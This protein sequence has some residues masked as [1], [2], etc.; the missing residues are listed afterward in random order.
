VSR[1][2][3]RWVAL[4]TGLV[5]GLALGLVY[6][7]LVTPVELVNTYPALLRADYRQEWV[8]LVALSYAADGDLARARSRL[9]G[10]DQQ[11]V[12]GAVAA[13]IEECASAGYPADTLRRL[14]ALAVALDVHTPAMLVYLHTPTRQPSL[15]P[16]TPTPSPSPTYTSSPTHAP[17]PSPTSTPTRTPIPTV[18]S[19][20]STPT[21]RPTDTPL[22]PTPTPAPGPAFLV[23]DQQQL[24]ERGQKPHI[25]VIV[26]DERGEGLAGVEI[27][28][29]WSGGADRAV[30]GLKPSEGAGYADF[31]AEA[32]VNYTLA[33]GEPGMPL[34]TGLRIEPCPVEKDEEP[35]PA[36]WRIVIEQRSA[37]TE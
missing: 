36:S 12:K 11:E 27:W 10:L 21:A 3:A 2:T 6:T 8:R 9:E 17:S 1:S 22:P 35:L 37:A 15:V 24:C 4:V 5:I 7:W 19:P 18:L 29:M 32:G 26:Q 31:S 34:V 30:S 23:V 28:L 13:V 25:E 16:P 33:I 20:L 14:T